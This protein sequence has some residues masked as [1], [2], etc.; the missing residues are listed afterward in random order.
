LRAAGFFDTDGLT[1]EEA[2]ARRQAKLSISKP[3][4][5]AFEQLTPDEK[6]LVGRV[7]VSGAVHKNV[8]T[9]ARQ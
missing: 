3:L 7:Q 1:V 8:N 9:G 2:A 5:A 6:A 4:E